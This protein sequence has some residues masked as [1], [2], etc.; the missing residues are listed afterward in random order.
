M[1]RTSAGFAAAPSTVKTAVDFD[2]PRGGCDCHVH[3]LDPARFP[4]LPQRPFTPAAATVE[5]LRDLSRGLRLDRVVIVQPGLYGTNNSCTLDAVRQLGPDARAIA[6]I[7]KATPREALEEMAAAGF[8][9]VRLPFEL[10][11]MTDP[12][13]I[14]A[15]IDAVTE[16]IR[17][18]NWHLTLFTRLSVIAQLKDYI[19]QLP[20]PVV[21][22]HFGQA[23]AAQGPN[24]PGFD[25]LA[26]LA[27]KGGVYV[28]IS[29]ANRISERAPDYAD[30]TPLA[31]ALITSNQD[32]ILWGSDWPHLPGPPWKPLAEI[33]APLP[34]DNGLVLNQ[35]PKWVAD[36]AVRKKIL[37]DNPTRLYGFQPIAG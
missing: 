12:V 21:F 9:G 34:I 6:V 29:G 14:K 24:Q 37:V 35:L 10:R 20:G 27:G 28:K 16:Q 26:E 25:A 31:Q 19:A 11:G 13:A 4:Y 30:A 2:V 17:G 8:R 15:A 33:S 18:L 32:R 7:D 5:D 3:V 1:L 23:A 36:P 22:D